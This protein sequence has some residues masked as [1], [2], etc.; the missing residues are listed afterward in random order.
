[1]SSIEI[2]K[3]IRAKHTRSPR[4]IQHGI[5]IIQN[6]DAGLITRPD[7]SGFGCCQLLQL[8][9]PCISHLPVVI[10]INFAYPSWFISGIRLKKIWS[11][12]RRGRPA[13]RSRISLRWYNSGRPCLATVASAQTMIP[14]GVMIM[15]RPV[16]WWRNTAETAFWKQRSWRYPVNGE[17]L[18]RLPYSISTRKRKESFFKISNVSWIDWK[19]KLFMK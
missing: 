4:E 5:F 7:R 6:L 11:L 13:V 14:R 15:V 3:R 19:Y 8:Q 2:N 1:M 17:L 18:Y 16:F 9:G 12:P 10:C